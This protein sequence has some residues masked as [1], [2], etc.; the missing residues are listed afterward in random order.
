MKWFIVVD[1]KGTDMVAEDTVLNAMACAKGY[2]AEDLGEDPKYACVL[3]V[4][5]PY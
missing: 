2:I 1:I 4:Q 5:G 3:T